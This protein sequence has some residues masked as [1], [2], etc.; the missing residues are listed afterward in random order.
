MLRGLT[1]VERVMYRVEWLQISKCLFEYYLSLTLHYSLGGISHEC[2]Y[3]WTRVIYV[4]VIFD[5]LD[6]VLERKNLVIDGRWVRG[7]LKKC[8]WDRNEI[9]D[10]SVYS[11]DLLERD[12]VERFL[13]FHRTWTELDYWIGWIMEGWHFMKRIPYNLAVFYLSYVLLLSLVL[14]TQILELSNQ[15]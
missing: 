7:C 5:F 10:L 15:Q 2:W 1:I 8:L 9:D 12:V 4:L 3:I 13:I 6:F 11:Y 14:I